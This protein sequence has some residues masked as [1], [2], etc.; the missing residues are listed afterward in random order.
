MKKI[1]N[2]C[3]KFLIW[4]LILIHI[5]S[6]YI[7]PFIISDFD[8]IYVQEVWDRWQAIIVGALA[9][10]TSYFIYEITKTNEKERRRKSLKAARSNLSNSLS[11]LNRYLKKCVPVY[12]DIWF[13]IARDKKNRRTATIVPIPEL[14][15]DH[16]ITFNKCI[17]YTD[18]EVVENHLISIITKLQIQHARI[19][20]FKKDDPSILESYG[21]ILYMIA[22]FL[23]IYTLV[24]K[25]YDYARF[26]EFSIN[27]EI[28]TS[29]IFNSMSNFDW[30]FDYFSHDAD[31]NL[32]R[33]INRNFKN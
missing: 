14:P 7:A 1:L 18:D 21:Y 27:P 12:E 19:L 8:W 13:N 23:E 22:D 9:T 16:E 15:K 31:V 32:R 3:F 20:E 24:N 10:I 6:M 33:I 25:T 26:K 17:E 11:S 5:Y 4:M 28:T 30:D 29:E 2:F